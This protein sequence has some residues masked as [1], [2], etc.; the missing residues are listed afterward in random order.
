MKYYLTLLSLV[1]FVTS[2]AF[3]Q[4]KVVKY[5]VSS[6]ETINQ[7]AVKF[8][9]TP[10]DIYTLNPDARNGVKPNTVLLIPTNGTK[11]AAKTE[12]V[13]AK[14]TNSS[15]EIVHE[16]QPKETFYS[17]EKKYGISDE[18]LKAAN[19]FL[20]KDGVQIGQKLVIPAKGASVKTPVANKVVSEKAKE[21]Y[22]YHDVIAKETKF[23]IAKKYN[24]TIEDLE[25]R[26]PEIVS[27]LPIGYRLT[28]KGTAPKTETSAAPVTNTAKPAETKKATETPKKAV[29]YMEYQ[30]KPKET[31]YSLGRTFH[32][33]QEELTALNP[34]LSEG[35]K[36][37]M[38]LKV[39]AGYLAPAPIIAQQQP[40]EKA[41]ENANTGGIQ[42]V[43][44]VKS[45]TVSAN[46]EIVELT[47][48]RGQNERKKL[49]LLL[50]FNLAKMQNDTTS[51]ANRIKSD[52]FLNMTLDFYSGA[53]MA[54]DSAKTLKLPI[55]VAIYDSQETKNSSNISTLIAQNKL[56]DA[57]AVIGPF[58]QSN[59]ESTA[60]TLRLYNVPVIS[61][62]SKD[63][64]NPIDNLYQ[65]IPSN[66][67]V[68]NAV[69]DFMRSK[70]G[71]IVAVVDKKKES[72]ISYIK[73][74]QKGVVFA[75]LTETGG[76]DV[77][78]LKS[79]LLPGRMNYV[80]METGN[81]AMV[82]ATIKALIDAQKTCQVQLV[83][84]EPNSTLDTDEINFDNLV[85]LKLMYPS[86]TRESDEPAVLVFEKE[87][88][89]K[90]KVNPNTYATRGF[91]VTF[92]TMMRLVQGKTYQETADLMTTEQVDNKF[93]FYKK[94]DGGHANKGVYILYYD[95]DLTL[96]V[97]N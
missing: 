53:M 27:N 24:T 71:N 42:I 64:A 4:E 52:K 36:E 25:K 19:P 75:G 7:I 80:V 2:S 15:K 11:A 94:E 78:S 28:I 51:T 46:P 70:N 96:K 3:S 40:V 67:V 74:N 26:N 35:V 62:L 47:K 87:Y 65:T 8:K 31:F 66:D 84:L 32:I 14:V 59:A 39:P 89:L 97:A 23:S 95:S 50:P 12:T 9:V 76:L 60:N 43:D 1:F 37:G 10:Y 48:K 34:A 92:D 69:F 21:K 18:A 56:Q 57:S 17:I 20:V 58:Y 63:K 13:V 6:G 38:V 79:L 30:V 45:E 54:I 61:P 33:S 81:T 73:Q 90:N 29:S 41:V 82:K 44:K 72:V 91:D 86:V 83:I 68:R 49:V 16:V 77:A 85:K 88:R 22:V 55:D 5:T 93:Q